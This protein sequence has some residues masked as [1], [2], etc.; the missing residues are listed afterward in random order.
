VSK[1]KRAFSKYLDF[2]GYVT[3]IDFREH[4][5]DYVWDHYENSV[6]MS[7]YLV[8]FVVSDFDF[9][10]SE[11]SGNNVTFRV[12]SRRNAIDQVEYANEVGPLM[13]KYFEEFFEVAYPLPKMVFVFKY[14]E[15]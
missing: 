6:P 1:C 13:L 8:A 9:K 3:Q 7:T 10:I 11:P 2:P 15:F 4:C 5:D 14:R 12:W